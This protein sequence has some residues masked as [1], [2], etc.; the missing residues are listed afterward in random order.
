VASVALAL[1]VVT[2]ALMAV[3]TSRP[4]AAGANGRPNGVDRPTMTPTPAPRLVLPKLPTHVGTIA[5]PP[6]GHFLWGVYVPGAPYELSRLVE[7]Q[8]F[9]ASTPGI[10]MWYQSWQDW[11]LFPVAEA[12]R[13]L[14]RGILPMLTWQPRHRVGDPVTITLQDIAEGRYDDYLRD[15][16][17]SVA[18]Y[19]GPLFLRFMHEMDGNWYPWSA[20]SRGNTPEL[21]VR[22][23]R[24]VHDIFGEEG[25]TNVTWV[26]SVNHHSVPKAPG[27]RIENF[28]PGSDYVDWIGMSGFNPGPARVP[29]RWESF[30]RVNRGRYLQLQRYGKPIVV[31]ETGSPEIGGNKAQ[32]LRSMFHSIRT[33]YPM[34]A[35]LI[36]FNDFD[37]KFPDRDDWRVNSSTSALA[38][39]RAGVHHSNV[40]SVPAGFHL[41]QSV[42]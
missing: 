26:W 7:T 41:V 21:W 39:F 11:P 37:P 27:N 16:A 38:A 12:R 25:A 6:T 17:R 18:R 5:A 31:C 9:V 8:R 30:D 22:V 28:W 33:D 19:G 2:F 4:Q 3:V 23:W 20:Y 13:V 32:W 34:L 36:W 35:G 24:H 40:V 42:R 29:F 1:S 15:Y 10:L 14:A